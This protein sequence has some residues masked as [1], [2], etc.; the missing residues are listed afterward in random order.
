MAVGS[1]AALILCAPIQPKLKR[2]KLESDMNS[3]ITPRRE[4]ELEFD[5]PNETASF[6][7]VESTY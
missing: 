7:P 2:Q 5:N 1:L 6:A 3:E 4:Q